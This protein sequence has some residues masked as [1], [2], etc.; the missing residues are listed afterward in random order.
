MIMKILINIFNKAI[1]IIMKFKKLIKLM[2]INCWIYKQIYKNKFI[3]KQKI[4]K[5][6]IK[7]KLMIQ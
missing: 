1:I 4:N 6:K 5:I 7:I 2:Q 3:K